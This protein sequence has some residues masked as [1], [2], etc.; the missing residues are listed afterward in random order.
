MWVYQK[1]TRNFIA[2]ALFK[3]GNGE[4]SGREMKIYYFSYHYKTIGQFLFQVSTLHE[5][6]GDQ[7]GTG[8]GNPDSQLKT[9]INYKQNIASYLL[10]WLYWMFYDHFSARS[11]LAKLGRWSYLLLILLLHEMCWYYYYYYWHF[12]ILLLLL[13]LNI[14]LFLMMDWSSH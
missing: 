14:L 7:I 5:V 4:C 3:I 8:K 6:L 13:Q 2:K 10:L 9:K 1:A 11:L 12:K